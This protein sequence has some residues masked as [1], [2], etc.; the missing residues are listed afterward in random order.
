M[1]RPGGLRLLRPAGFSRPMCKAAEKPVETTVTGWE[2]FKN[3]LP[4][5]VSWASA[6]YMYNLPLS[7][8]I[9]AQAGNG[10]LTKSLLDE[11]L[12]L[13]HALALGSLAVYLGAQ[14]FRFLL[15]AHM[16][17]LVNALPVLSTTFVV[18]SSR[19]AAARSAVVITAYYASAL[20][21]ATIVAELSHFDLAASWEAWHLAGLNI[22]VQD[23]CFFLVLWAFVAA[24]CFLALVRRD[25]RQFLLR[26]PTIFDRMLP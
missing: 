12:N 2:R 9:K 18:P 15:W 24:H 4:H 6:A 17:R 16:R 3:W 22:C 7:A 8:H 10:F 19:F 23:P 5:L 14:G 25:V 26:Q 21:A 20:S 11:R 1:P 13:G